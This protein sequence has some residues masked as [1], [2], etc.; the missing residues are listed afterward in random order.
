MRATELNSAKKRKPTADDFLTL[1]PAQLRG[2][3]NDLDDRIGDMRIDEEQICEEAGY[4]KL[5]AWG[6]LAEHLRAEAK[7]REAAK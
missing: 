2:L 5:A 3:A 7:D 6:A 4:D 1:T